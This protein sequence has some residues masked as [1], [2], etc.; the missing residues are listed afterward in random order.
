MFRFS[1]LSAVAILSLVGCSVENE[2][3]EASSETTSDLDAVRW[4]SV[5]RCDGA[6]IDSVDPESRSGQQLVIDDPAAAGYLRDRLN[7]AMA[8]DPFSSNVGIRSDAYGP[9]LRPSRPNEMVWALYG[10]A[11]FVAQP[12]L[13]FFASAGVTHGQEIRLDVQKTTWDQDQGG[14]LFRKVTDVKVR[15]VRNGWREYHCD[16]GLSGDPPSCGSTGEG[17]NEYEVANWTFRGCRNE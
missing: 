5:V 7:N 15:L 17:W 16:P 4:K 3:S 6:H 10:F 12:R 8:H 11:Q 14:G 13:D 1:L 2:S 9:V